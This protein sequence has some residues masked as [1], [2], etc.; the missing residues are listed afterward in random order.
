MAKEGTA[1]S[2]VEAERPPTSEEI[3]MW[4]KAEKIAKRVNLL[5]YIVKMQWLNIELT[6]TFAKSASI[7]LGEPDLPDYADRMFSVLNKIEPLKDAMCKVNQ[8]ELGIKISSSGNDLDIVQPQDTS[9]G[10]VIPVIGVS[11]IVAGVI[12]L[13]KELSD[14]LEEITQKYNGVLKK[15]DALI[16]KN[17]NDKICKDWEKS[18]KEKN[19]YKRESIID[20]VKSALVSFGG[21]AKKGL[22]W[23]VALLL[24]VLALLY[25][26]RRR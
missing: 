14:D 17:P 18:K 10:W 21:A 20:S 12:G 11:L 6:H 22:G 24:P 23:G 15:A 19:Y 5:S 9:F 4:E 3:S 1:I 2:Y 26:P 13:W 25:L 16:C 8:L 7:E